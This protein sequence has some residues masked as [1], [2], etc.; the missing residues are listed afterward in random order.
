M[1]DQMSLHLGCVKSERSVNS[2]SKQAL[3]S[4]SSIDGLRSQEGIL[5]EVHSQSCC[6]ALLSALTCAVNQNH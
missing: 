1:I 4:Y 2:K 5:C 6:I 3:I